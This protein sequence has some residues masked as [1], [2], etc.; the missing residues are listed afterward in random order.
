VSDL[1]LRGLERAVEEDPKNEAARTELVAGMLRAA[2]GHILWWACPRKIHPSAA[3]LRLES[4]FQHELSKD[5][6]TYGQDGWAVA[7]GS[8]QD[9]I[10]LSSVY[11][12]ATLIDLTTGRWARLQG[13][14]S[15]GD[16]SLVF[17]S[18]A[19]TVDALGRARD[20]RGQQHHRPL[21]LPGGPFA[22]APGDF[23]SWP[24]SSLRWRSEPLFDTE[25]F[26]QGGLEVNLFQNFNAFTHLPT[27]KLWGVDTNL[28]GQGGCLPAT[29]HAQILGVTVFLLGE[30]RRPLPREVA[31]QIAHSGCVRLETAQTTISAIPFEQTLGNAA[32]ESQESG[33]VVPWQPP[34]MFPLAWPIELLPLLNFRIRVALPT[35][36]Q[37]A[38]FYL[39]VVL[40]SL[41]AK[42]VVG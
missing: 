39:K 33:V 16:Q 13:R 32:E 2:R 42:G 11:R 23:S 27:Q 35:T 7:V 24:P 17:A 20:T 10:D 34:P 31:E 3:R 22:R 15:F 38:P 9:L 25:L 1:H 4:R 21:D 30:D 37:R 29:W 26:P 36:T 5:W 8:V 40:H 18:E 14:Q 12:T 28:V 6:H 19:M 41:V